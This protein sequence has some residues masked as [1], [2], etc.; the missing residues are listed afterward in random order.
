MFA[1]GR[2]PEF[3][4]IDPVHVPCPRCGATNRIPAARLG[5]APVC[6]KCRTALLDGR[7]IDIHGAD[8]D[9]QVG[10]D[11]PVVVDFWASWCGPCRTM[12]PHFERA[13]AALAP[14]VRFAKVD[15][16][17]A[18]DVAARYGI[19]SIPTVIAFRNGCEVARRSGAMDARSLEQ[20]VRQSV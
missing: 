3:A 6:G 9:R 17:A 4:M 1:A 7:P 10:G 8:F 20:W 12:A 18:Q 14:R 2:F 5:E 13:A 11:L 19:R 16:E 15:T